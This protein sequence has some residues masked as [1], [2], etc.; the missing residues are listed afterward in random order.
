MAEYI[1]KEALRAFPIRANHCDR[2]HANEHFI[3]GIETV[4]EYVENLP[5]ADVTPV[6][7]GRWIYEE[8]TLATSSG[9]RCSAC[10]RP[11]WLS[12]DVPEAFKYCPKCGAKMD[13]GADDADD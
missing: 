7:H 1:T 11:R 5:A 3:S 6:V 10:R 4:M 2:E 12:P 13:G 8:E 9:Y